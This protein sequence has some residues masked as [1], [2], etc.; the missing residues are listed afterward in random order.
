MLLI[1]VGCGSASKPMADKQAAPAKD[2]PAQ[3]SAKKAETGTSGSVA[4]SQTCSSDKDVRKLA[5]H[6]ANG[7][8][9]LHYEKFGE[10]QVVATARSGEDYCQEVMSRIS[11]KLEAAGFSCK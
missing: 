10:D 11:S 5:I 1:A 2:Q 6:S 3:P 8:C 4:Q 9:E 7:G